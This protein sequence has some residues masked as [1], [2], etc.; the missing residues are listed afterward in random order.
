MTKILNAAFKLKTNKN[1]SKFELFNFK[2]LVCCNI[3]IA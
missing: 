1:F 2:V 3:E